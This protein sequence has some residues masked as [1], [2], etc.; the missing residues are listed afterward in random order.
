MDHFGWISLPLVKTSRKWLTLFQW[1]LPAFYDL[2]ACQAFIRIALIPHVHTSTL[3]CHPYHTAMFA[4]TN[5]RKLCSNIRESKRADE[6]TSTLRD[7]CVEGVQKGGEMFEPSRFALLSDLLSGEWKEAIL[8]R[9]PNAQPLLEANVTWLRSLESHFSEPAGP[10]KRHG[11]RY[12]RRSNLRTIAKA[13]SL[14]AL[15]KGCKNIEEAVTHA[16]DVICS[17]EWA[18]YY[19]DMINDPSSLLKLPSAATISRYRLLVDTGFMLYM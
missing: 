13:V 18:T 9:D 14:G 11:N 5:V 16:L 1:F 12:Y 15:L 7:G 10:S 8:S 3:S 4:G 19:K 6:P 17:N 2:M